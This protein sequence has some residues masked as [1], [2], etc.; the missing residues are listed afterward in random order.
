MEQAAQLVCCGGAQKNGTSGSTCVLRG[1]TKKWNKR[2]NLCAA[3]VHKKM[4]QAAQLVCLVCRKG[5]LNHEKSQ[6]KAFDFQEPKEEKI[7][8]ERSF[9]V[10]ERF[11]THKSGRLE[12]ERGHPIVVTSFRVDILD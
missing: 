10:K 3:G 7:L 9:T 8:F 4:E 5:F 6:Q 1:C 2:L 11:L 12:N